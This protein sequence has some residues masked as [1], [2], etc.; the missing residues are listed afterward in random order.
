MNIYDI[1]VNLHI[2]RFFI[3]RR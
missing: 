1:P 2:L 3:Y